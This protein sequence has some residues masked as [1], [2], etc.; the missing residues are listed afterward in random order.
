M[1][2]DFNSFVYYVWRIAPAERIAILAPCAVM[3]KHKH[4]AEMPA[5][6]DPILEIYFEPPFTVNLTQVIT[7]VHHKH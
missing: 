2:R 3:G 6:R 5:N 1:Q 4:D 7:D